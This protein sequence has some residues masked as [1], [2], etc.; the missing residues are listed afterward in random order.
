[1]LSHFSIADDLLNAIRTILSTLSKTGCTLIW[2]STTYRVT[3]NTACLE[4]CFAKC[5]WNASKGRM[6]AVEVNQDHK[7]KLEQQQGAAGLAGHQLFWEEGVAY[8]SKEEEDGEVQRLVMSRA[9]G[10][11][12]LT[13]GPC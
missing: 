11:F 12:D 8:L 13:G 4:S 10:D 9:L 7:P 3:L 1:M 6:E 5:R 2:V